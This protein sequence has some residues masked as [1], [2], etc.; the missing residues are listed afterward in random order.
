MKQA[1]PTA[2][3]RHYQKEGVAHLLRR[4]FGGLLQDPGTGKTL[5]VLAAFHVLLKR[6]LVDR[7]VVV[8]PLRPC[9]SVWPAE[10]E[11]WRFGFSV[12]VAHG[13]RKAEALEAHAQVTVVNYEGLDWLRSNWV[14]FKGRTR[15]HR[16]ER[17][18]LVL[19]ESTK[20]KNRT[21]Q[22][23]VA[24]GEMLRCFSR[25]S[26]LTGTPVPNGLHD[27]FGQV[28][29][30]DLGEA[31]G[32]YVTQYRR[33]YFDKVGFGGYAHVPQ[34]G[35]AKKIYRKLDGL[36]YRVGDDVL[37]L[38]P[39]HVNIIKVDLPQKA[40]RLYDRLEEEFVAELRGA[41]ITAVNAGVLSSKLR[42]VANGAV[43][44]AAHR[45]HAVHD[46][47]LE[48]LVD[49]AEELEGNPLFVGYEFTS[50]AERLRRALK[51]ALG[52]DPPVVG[53]GM[54]ARKA[55]AVFT[56]FN[57]GK[58]PVLLCQSDAVAHGLNLQEACHTV[59]RFGVG[60]NLETMLQFV[61]R[62]HRSGQTRTVMDH[63]LVARDTIED[64]VML[65]VMGRKDAT[66][67]DFLTAIKRRYM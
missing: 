59:A 5:E 28:Y 11:K 63:R 24:L 16:A 10:I 39:L 20:I 21:A 37:R 50:D 7:L 3:L 13:P 32:R 2:V 67:R 65:P 47:K 44:D 36:F 25:R 27:L 26:I 15:A 1:E 38:P 64:L 51:R 55:D 66:Q 62:V 58:W 33:A 12:A 23:S 43:Y 29:A 35:A 17:L 41:T 9:Y 40:R 45:A 22:R 18:W 60:W 57:A 52:E 49:L 6:G 30:V 53:G 19:D 42:Q 34:E 61:K 46:A 56:E 54:T 31:F 14:R 48:A 4:P 8:A